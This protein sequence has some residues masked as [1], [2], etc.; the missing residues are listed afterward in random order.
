MQLAACFYVGKISR[1]YSY[2]GE[3]I[4]SVD[5]DFPE[6]IIE[7]ESVYITLGDNLVPFF[8]ERKSWQKKLQLRV[9]FEDIDSESD[10]D[11]LVNKKVY[12]PNDIL[13]KREGLDFYQNEIL[14]FKVEDTQYGSVGVVVGVN[15]KTPQTLLEVKDDRG[16]VFIPVNEIFIKKIDRKNQL[17]IVE[18]PEGLLDLRY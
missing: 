6:I 18:T 13:P 14:D 5:S 15:D 10:A 9:K 16:L 17:I 11:E 7:S 1:K 8:M 4:I 2:K 12:L 3:L